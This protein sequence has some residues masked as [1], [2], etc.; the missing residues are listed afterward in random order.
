MFN[1]TNPKVRAYIYTVVAAAGA[2]ALVYGALNAQ[3]LGV[4]LSL[5]GAALGL[6]NG[7]A[8]LNV[9]KNSPVDT[10]VTPGK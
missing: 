7:L 6:T 8:L 2:V 1:I 3:Q 5:A 4:W 9:P 10:G